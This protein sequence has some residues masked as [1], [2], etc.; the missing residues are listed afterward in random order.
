[1]EEKEKKQEVLEKENGEGEYKKKEEVGKKTWGDVL[2]VSKI[3]DNV[4]AVD[5]EHSGEDWG[6]AVK[7]GCIL[8]RSVQCRHSEC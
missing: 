2:T 3:V 8:H 6:G 4:E 5:E 7:H 1:M